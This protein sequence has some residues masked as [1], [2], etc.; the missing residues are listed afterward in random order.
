[1]LTISTAFPCTVFLIYGTHW[2]SLALQMDPT[3][4]IAT[5]FDAYGGATGAAYN[6][7]QGFH[8]VTMTLVSFV[9]FIATFRVN[10]LFT[11]T[12]FGLICLFAFTAAADFY[13]PSITT[14]ADISHLEL[15]LR[16]AGGFG[17]I[18]AVCGWYLCILTSCAAVGI[19][20]PLPVFD[21][22]T[23]VF[24]KK[25]DKGI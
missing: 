9:F 24:S 19:P 2:C 23:K 3:H 5:Y 22:S 21:L 6:S 1:M 15:L 25:T 11:L 4:G 14:L 8:N 12:F 10:F 7:S 16:L 20:C 17:M 13:V 18:G